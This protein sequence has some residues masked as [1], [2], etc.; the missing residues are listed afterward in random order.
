MKPTRLALAAGTAAAMAL[1]ASGALANDLALIPGVKTTLSVKAIPVAPPLLSFSDP[2]MR[3]FF[4]QPFLPS[5]PAVPCDAA[6]KRP[7]KVS[8][9][10]VAAG[11]TLTATLTARQ[12]RGGNPDAVIHQT[13]ILRSR[14]HPDG[15]GPPDALIPEL[16]FNGP[17]QGLPDVT[18]VK[19]KAKF[20]V[21]SDQLLQANQLLFPAPRPLCPSDI[22]TIRHLLEID[23]CWYEAIFTVHHAE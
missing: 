2:T 17:V 6:L 10:I 13:V 16:T 11:G 1:A 8:A 19:G 14:L 7:A 5:T 22:F 21:T 4:G 23:G 18:L 20:V 12:G 3:T 9:K 15:C